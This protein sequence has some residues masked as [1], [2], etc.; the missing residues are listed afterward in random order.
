MN[1]PFNLKHRTLK[2]ALVSAF[3]LGSIGFGVNSYAATQTANGTATIVSAISITKVADL[4]FGTVAPHATLTG[5]VV[6][7]P[8]GGRTAGGSATLSAVDTGGAASFTVD[9]DSTATYVITLPSTAVTISNGANNMTIDT[10][11]SN[12]S[13]TGLLAGGTQNLLVGGTLNV[14]AAQVAGS[15]TG[16]FDVS[17]DYN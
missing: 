2:L 12:P 8:A 10:F 5:T 15:Y 14:A 17:V 1:T 4:R 7:T 11:T 9:G 16:T 13:G 6:M 3:A